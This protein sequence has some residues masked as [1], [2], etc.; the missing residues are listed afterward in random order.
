M[1]K[2]KV[3]LVIH[4]LKLFIYHYYELND[5]IVM[6]VLLFLLVFHLVKFM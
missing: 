5:Y 1:T 3:H 4:S 6:F 2:N